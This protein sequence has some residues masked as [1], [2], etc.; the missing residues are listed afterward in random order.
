MVSALQKWQEGRSASGS[1]LKLTTGDKGMD[2][3]LGGGV[4]AGALSEVVGQSASGKTQVALQTAVYA[5]LALDNDASVR[6]E[7]E[8]RS[9]DDL[10]LALQGQGIRPARERRSVIYIVFDGRGELDLVTRRMRQICAALIETRWRR[11]DIHRRKVAEQERRRKQKKVVGGA[12]AASENER[13]GLPELVELAHKTMMGNIHLATMNG[14][15]MLQHVL[16]HDVPL[17]LAQD[18]R[19]PFG[20]IVLDDVTDCIHAAAEARASHPSQTT[21]ERAKVCAELSDLLKTIAARRDALPLAILVTNHVVDVIDQHKDVLRPCVE[22]LLDG[23]QGRPVYAPY[24]SQP[25]SGF[26]NDLALATQEPRYTGMTAHLHAAAIRDMAI[27]AP[28]YLTRAQLL[29]NVMTT[30]RSAS[31]GLSWVNCINVRIVLAH[32]AREVVLGRQH[33]KQ[34]HDAG[35]RGS[36]RFGVRRAVS[37]LNPFAPTQTSLEYIISADGVRSLAYFGDVKAEQAR[38]PLDEADEDEMLWHS[39][40]DATMAADEDRWIETIEMSQAVV[41]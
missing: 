23:K 19:D 2:E 32:T 15:G 18:D 10:F 12:F 17:L 29:E 38:A 37:V 8:D 24:I 28:S 6:H 9:A 31:L 14:Y 41:L 20:L 1:K 25:L 27:N 36:H 7:R 40:G 4:H 39:V 21:V 34:L 26:D 30:L 5:A 3:L 16:R 13:L 22:A 11:A 33:Y 35:M